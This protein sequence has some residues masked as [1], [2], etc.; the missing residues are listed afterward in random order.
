MKVLIT[1]GAGFIGGNFI[2]YQ[3]QNHPQDEFI[4]LDEL[5]YAGN[6]ETLQP[7]M[8]NNNFKFVKGDIAIGLL[9]TSCLKQKNLM[10]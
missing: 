5:K 7:V 8:H 4:C 1:G 9:F 6:L 2:Y 3:L 10:L